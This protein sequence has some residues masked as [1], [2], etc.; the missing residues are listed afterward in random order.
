MPKVTSVYGS[1]SLKLA[2]NSALWQRQAEDIDL[3]CGAIVDGEYSV[4]EMGQMVFDEILAVASG[5]RTKSEK[6]GYGQNEFIPW[7]IG[8][9]M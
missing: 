7:Q 3:N 9:V 4:A 8:T 2:T 6:H 5:E 1:P